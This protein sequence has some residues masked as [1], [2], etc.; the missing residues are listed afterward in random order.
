VKKKIERRD[1][2]KVQFYE[3]YKEKE[4]PISV[5]IDNREI[6]IL[7]ILQRK[8]VQDQKTGKIKEIFTCETEEGKIKVTI[9]QSGESVI[10]ITGHCE[11]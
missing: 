7:R 4:T 8:R 5:T 11:D 9:S 2:A 10:P 1:E 3:G 6:K